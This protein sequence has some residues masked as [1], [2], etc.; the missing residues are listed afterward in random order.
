MRVRFPTKHSRS[1][2]AAGETIPY[3]CFTR[4]QL[5]SFEPSDRSEDRE[6]ELVIANPRRCST[7]R[8][9][10]QRVNFTTKVAAAAAMRVTTPV[11]TA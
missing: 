1:A 10:P 4:T 2:S 9:Q 11:S 7:G 8:D 5:A 6:H 3:T